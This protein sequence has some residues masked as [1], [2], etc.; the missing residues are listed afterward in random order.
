MPSSINRDDFGSWY[1][2]ASSC[3]SVLCFTLRMRRTPTCNAAKIT[4]VWKS[5][6]IFT[7]FY[8]HLKPSER[9]NIDPKVLWQ[10]K[11]TPPKNKSAQSAAYVMVAHVCVSE[12]ILSSFSMHNFIDMWLYLTT[13][14]PKTLTLSVVKWH[15]LI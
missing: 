14:S 11:W 9:E 1:A 4:A 5:I 2:G 3:Y 15:G 12:F 13:G 7:W 8:W 10:S 6:C